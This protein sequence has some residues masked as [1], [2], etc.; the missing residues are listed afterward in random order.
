[1]VA[2]EALTIYDNVPDLLAKWYALSGDVTAK[3][4]LKW[5]KYNSSPNP[6]AT[7]GN[8]FVNN[9]TNSIAN[10]YGRIASGEYLHPDSVIAKDNLRVTARRNV[11]T[12]SLFIMEKLAAGKSPKSKDWL[13]KINMPDSSF[14]GDTL[15]DNA[16]KVS[17]CHECHSTELIDDYL[18]F[19]PKE[20]R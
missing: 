20:Y 4:Y 10:K 11:F 7:H 17:F 8:R 13:Y 14:F 19:M 3:S 1:M 5:Q 6:S 9:Y 15:G 18:F 16:D 2:I 12:G